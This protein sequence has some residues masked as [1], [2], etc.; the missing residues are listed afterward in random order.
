MAT[1]NDIF[2]SRARTCPSE[3]NVLVAACFGLLWFALVLVE[4]SISAGVIQKVEATSS[5]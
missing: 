5:H 2:A 3:E 1:G 4:S